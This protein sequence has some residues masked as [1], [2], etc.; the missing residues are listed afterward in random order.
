MDLPIELYFWT[1]DPGVTGETKIITVF[2]GMKSFKELA[3]SGEDIL[4]YAWNKE[5]KLPEISTLRNPRV[6]REN[7]PL[8]E[9]VF[10]SGLKIKCTFDHSFYSFRG[11]K[12]EA[13]N[14]IVGQSIRAFSMSE[15]KD[16]HIRVHGWVDGKAKHQYVARMVWE[17]YN[18]KV[19]DKMIIHHKDFHKQN[20]AP[21]NLQ[22]LTNSAHNQVHYPYRRDGGFFHHNHK[23]LS[24]TPITLREDVYNGDVD[25][26]FTFIIADDV[27]VSGMAS[28]IV[29]ASCGD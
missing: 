29:S 10:D 22:L 1:I 5:T 12:V 9:V 25:S 27:P 3:E 7:E 14:L 8:V 16:G 19:P 11:E 13:Q 21:E 2:Q 26:V 28:G 23:V 4:I 15:H 20:N 24:V 6:T 17:Y 18:G